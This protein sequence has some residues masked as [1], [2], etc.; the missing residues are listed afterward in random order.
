MA[1]LRCGEQ[2]LPLTFTNEF[3]AHLHVAVHRRFTHAGGFFLTGS[4][5]QDGHEV[6]VSY[7]LAPTT[8]LVFT[9]VVRDESGER[10][11]PVELDHKEIDAILEAM[12]R[13][14]G[15]HLTGEVW[16]TF[17]DRV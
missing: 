17:R 12:D 2:D 3:L 1:T 8:P 11:P 13:P 14:V 6:T 4:Y 10:I 5:P 9:Y 16:L 7:W 15:V